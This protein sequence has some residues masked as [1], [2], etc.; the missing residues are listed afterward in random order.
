MTTARKP[1]RPREFPPPRERR[2]RAAWAFA[3]VAALG[4]GGATG[5]IRAQE[6]TPGTG[7]DTAP[8]VPS[9]PPAPPPSATAEPDAGE[10]EKKE[11]DD[12]AP[13]FIRV[14]PVP[15]AVR[16]RDG[17]VARGLLLMRS[18]EGVRLIEQVGT[19]ENGRDAY[20]E[21]WIPGRDVR[22]VDVDDKAPSAT[23]PAPGAVRPGVTRNGVPGR[24]PWPG[25]VQ[26]HDPDAP[27]VT[28]SP[29]VVERDRSSDAVTVFP[30]FRADMDKGRYVVTGRVDPGG[31]QN[32]DETDGGP[33]LP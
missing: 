28:G 20:R 10:D 12:V 29:P 32:N 31:E 6:T 3:V 23:T 27:P 30:R 25:F 13:A 7:A 18:P 14:V 19:D 24:R 33:P 1:R 15:V 21:R 9:T 11:N 16:R 22:S 8:P 5:S 4:L 26:R 17:S 2:F